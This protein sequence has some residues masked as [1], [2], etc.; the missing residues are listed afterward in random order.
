M[1]DNETREQML[2]RRRNILLSKQGTL[3]EAETLW[4]VQIESEL[5]I[6]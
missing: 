2:L 5:G 1:R 4:L 6:N 3:N